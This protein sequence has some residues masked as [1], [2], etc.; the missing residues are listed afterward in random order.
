MLIPKRK[1][2]KKETTHLFESGL[3]SPPPLPDPNLRSLI[4]E[5]DIRLTIHQI[6]Q[7]LLIFNSDLGDP[8]V[9]FGAD[10]DRLGRL[11]ER[12]VRLDD[13]AGRGGQDVR[14]RFDGFD[15]ADGIARRDGEID[16]RQF[17]KDHVAELFGRVVRDANGGWSMSRRVSASGWW[18]IKIGPGG[19]E[20]QKMGGYYLPVFPSGPNSIHSCSSVYFFSCAA[21]RPSIR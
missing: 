19:R 7:L 12:G 10:I 13:C 1:K 15:G 16:R 11:F 20:A 5:L 6:V 14:G 8:A 9:R 21:V 18:V 4:R 17:D 3:P 2:E